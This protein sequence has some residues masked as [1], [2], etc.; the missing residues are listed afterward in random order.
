MPER[1]SEGGCFAC[2]ETKT[3]GKNILHLEAATSAH[4]HSY[5]LYA[6]VFSVF[7]VDLFAQ[8]LNYSLGH[9]LLF[10]HTIYSMSVLRIKLHVIMIKKKCIFSVGLL[11]FCFHYFS[12]FLLCISLHQLPTFMITWLFFPTWNN[13]YAY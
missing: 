12:L 8:I 1:L 11:I 3:M 4:C 13:F 9:C 6:V 2:N 5:I 7:S 10:A